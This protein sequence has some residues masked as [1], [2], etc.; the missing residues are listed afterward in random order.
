[1][2]VPIYADS[3]ADEMAYVLEH[4]EI[5]IVVAE[6]QEQVDKVTSIADRVPTLRHITYDEPR[7]PARL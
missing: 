2:P 7:G 4:A 1:V 5:T 6:N 3:V